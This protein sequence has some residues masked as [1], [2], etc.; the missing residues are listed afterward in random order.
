MLASASSQFHTR[1]RNVHSDTSN[2]GALDESHPTPARP[3]SAKR[4]AGC[5]GAGQVV[6]YSDL[7]DGNNHAFRWTRQVEPNLK[8]L[9]LTAY[10]D[11]LFAEKRTLRAD[12]AF[13]EKPSSVEAVVEA[14]SLLLHG[15]LPSYLYRHSARSR[16][17]S[18]HSGGKG[19]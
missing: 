19:L 14:V 13:L 8:V 4:H 9:Y 17:S 7:P 6:G 10:G 18:R 5:R 11:Q 2:L 3:G 12:E 16:A 1:C 15:Q